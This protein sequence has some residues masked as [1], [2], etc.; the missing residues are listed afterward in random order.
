ME[1]IKTINEN[2]S[3]QTKLVAA[4]LILLVLFL[5]F[6]VYGTSVSNR[7][8]KL[9]IVTS[10]SMSPEFE[11]GDL[12]MIV[13]VD[14]YELK[15]DDIITFSTEDGK[16]LTH[17]IVELKKD[18]EII[19]KGDANKTADTWSGG[20]KLK[21]ADTKYIAKFPMCGKV[22]TLLQGLIGNNTGAWLK[23]TKKIGMNFNSDEWVTEPTTS[24]IESI[25]PQ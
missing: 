18:G 4:F 15:V 23:D 24:P 8:Y 13:R 6:I 3:I 7:F 17:R 1:E 9:L 14:P 22:L 2:S 11:A 5:S 21:K 19:T 25:I 12:I 20:W 16:L 10:G